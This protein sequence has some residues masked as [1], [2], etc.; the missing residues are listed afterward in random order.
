MIIQR[1]QDETDDALHSRNVEI[2]TISPY[3]LPTTIE[4]F[5]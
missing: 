1:C 2:L 3:I 4:E 5:L